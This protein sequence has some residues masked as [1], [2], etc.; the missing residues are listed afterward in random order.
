MERR[1]NSEMVLIASDPIGKTGFIK[2]LW[3]HPLYGFF[4]LFNGKSEITYDKEKW[5]FRQIM[6]KYNSI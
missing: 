5:T 3:R 6:D 1:P 2:K 4:I